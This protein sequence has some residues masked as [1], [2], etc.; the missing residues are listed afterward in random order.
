MA[1]VLFLIALYTVLDYFERFLCVMPSFNFDFFAFEGFVDLKE[2]CNFAQNMFVD[3]LDVLGFFKARV[4]VRHALDFF[5]LFPFV[6]HVEHSYWPCL[7][8]GHRKSRKAQQ[9]KT[10]KRVAIFSK[11]LRDESIIAWVMHRRE[12]DTV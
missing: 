9:D 11:R 7:D 1:L 5:V 6:N 12:Q 2:V 4:I 8:K 3:V 10:V